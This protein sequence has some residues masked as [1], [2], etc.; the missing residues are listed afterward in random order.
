M[1]ALQE[2]PVECPY[3]GEVIGLLVDDSVPAQT[4]VEDCEVCCQ[5]MVVRAAVRADGSCRV[6]VRREDDW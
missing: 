5:P 4:Y 3:C 2:V 6:E 1:N